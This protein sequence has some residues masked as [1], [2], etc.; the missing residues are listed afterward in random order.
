M[1]SYIASQVHR[2]INLN[3]S[4]EYARLSPCHFLRIFKKY[5]NCSPY[6]YLINYRIN[7]AKRLLHNTKL[8]VQEIAYASGFNSVPHCIQIFKKHTNLS[9]EKFRDIQF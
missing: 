9:P 5:M 4:A 6:Q 8:S 7:N 3:D 2:S 1:Y